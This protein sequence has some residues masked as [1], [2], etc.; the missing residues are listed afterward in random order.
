MENVVKAKK[1]V[2]KIG[3]STLTHKT[4]N[5][6]IRR[7]EHLVKIISD[8]KNS[9]KEIVLVSSGAVGV[10][11][12]K[13]GLDKKPKTISKRQALAAIGQ[14]EL[15]YLYDKLFGEYNHNVAQVLLTNDVVGENADISNIYNTFEQLLKY[16]VIPIVN[17]NDTVSTEEL[18]F[19]DNDTLSAVVSSIIGA[20]LLVILTDID[21]LY[22]DNPKKNKNAKRI[23]VVEE[24]TDEII[25]CCGGA[26]NNLGTG[27]MITKIRAGQIAFENNFDMVI[28]SS[29]NPDDLYSLFDGENKGTL[30]KVRWL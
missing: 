27:G 17:E 28:L 4:G 13:L 9:G 19:G 24:I 22:T 21:G 10:G 16:N 2:I 7:V 18:E 14:C 12:G 3:T 25:D 26:V 20:D 6:N 30:F 8:L 15:M 29:K 23:E 5:I 1:I 11:M